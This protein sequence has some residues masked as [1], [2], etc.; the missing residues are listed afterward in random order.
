MFM[1]KIT[2]F[3]LLAMTGCK[4][5]AQ[6]HEYIPLLEEGKRW[7]YI[8]D[9]A[10]AGAPKEYNYYYS[11]FVNGDTVINNITCKKIYMEKDGSVTYKAAM[12]EDGQKVYCF[13]NNSTDSELLYD[14]GL[15]RYDKMP[16]EKEN[17]EVLC[18]YTKQSEYEGVN[19]KE[20]YWIMIDSYMSEDYVERMMSLDNDIYLSEWIEGIGSTQDL[21]FTLP[22]DGN[23]SHMI[24]CE[25]N[26]KTLYQDS[27][28]TG[29][30]DIRTN[31]NVS[32]QIFDF[33]GRRLNSIPEKGMYIKGG[34]KY[35]IKK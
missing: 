27:Y 18:K 25:Q 34:R 21:F 28:Y 14:F 16:V 17:V 31:S 32:S 11:Y 2:L 19:R 12:Y 30:I 9:F 26:G 5:F 29:I 15:C 23:Y 20:I 33:S 13:N 8:F 22:Y 1:K 35:L 24:S 6:E 7:N 4:C 10:W 3:L